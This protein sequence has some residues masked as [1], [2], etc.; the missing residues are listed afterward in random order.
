MAQISNSFKI[1][2]LPVNFCST[3]LP[4]HWRTGFVSGTPSTFRTQNPFTPRFSVSFSSLSVPFAPAAMDPA[5]FDARLE[6][7][8]DVRQNLTTDG[9]YF[10][11]LMA[12]HAATIDLGDTVPVSV[13]LASLREETSQLKASYIGLRAHE[14]YLQSL[15]DGRDAE[16]GHVFPTVAEY[17]RLDQQT[18]AAKA[19]LQTA[20][21]E[22]ERESKNV[23]DACRLVA[24]AAVVFEDGKEELGRKI[25]EARAGNRLKQVLE[26]LQNGSF[27]DVV[28]LAEQ[29]DDLDAA[30]CNAV[31]KKISGMAEKAERLRME[32]GAEIDGLQNEIDRA[33]MRQA[34]L[35]MLLSDYKAQLNQNEV[36]NA[37]AQKYR[38]LC[39]K[40]EK[41][42]EFMSALTLTKAAAVHDD[43]LSIE[44]TV[45]RTLRHADGAKVAVEESASIDYTMDMCLAKG[46]DSL[47]T[48]VFLTPDPNVSLEHIVS[49]ERPQSVLQVTQDVVFALLEQPIFVSSDD[50]SI[51][52]QT[53][54]A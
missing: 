50:T 49:D 22:R 51:V 45:I 21:A 24:E 25:A 48:N 41:L 16:S 39:A 29:A 26:V 6:V 1:Q 2:K 38:E 12:T 37:D 4:L 8:D 40:H 5:E 9:L 54:G 34:E 10:R 18:A 3:L 7:V 14:L 42:C 32:E 23:E 47:V 33:V 36:R 52:S 44:M 15:V 11:T 46:S 43:S 28:R 20:K 30:A 19:V 17:A 27:D 31:L 35:N 13:K 53:L